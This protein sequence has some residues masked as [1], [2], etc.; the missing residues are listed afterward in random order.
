MEFKEFKS[1]IQTQ[2]KKMSNGYYPLFTVNTNKDELWT[3]YMD[4]YPAGTN[5]LFRKRREFECSCCRQFIKNIANVVVLKNGVMSSI[6]DITLNNADGDETFK[7]VADAMSKYVKSHAINNIYLSNESRVGTEYNIE[8]TGTLYQWEHFML[9][10]PDAYVHKNKHESIKS[11]QKIARS[12]KNV[13]QRSLEEISLD[14]VNTALELIQS[15]SIYKE[16]EWE[17]SLN[18]FRRRKLEYDDITSNNGKDFYAWEESTHV[19]TVVEKIRN[20]SIGTLLT[21]IT[22]G[23]KLDTAVKKYETNSRR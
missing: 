16:E 2:F 7:T 14:A 21:D 19:G 6:W 8:Q 17:S 12:T 20:H 10:V 18:I 11:L 1:A 15:N 4:T 3:Y 23:I 5:K 13:F 9:N 22:N